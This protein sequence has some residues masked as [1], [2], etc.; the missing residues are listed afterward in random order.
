MYNIDQLTYHRSIS[1]E[2]I[3]HQ[4]IMTM[5]TMANMMTILTMMTMVTMV[6]MAAMLEVGGWRLYT[7]KLE[8]V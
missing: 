2:A 6:T 1:D 7:R 8:V 4:N 3:V 5:T